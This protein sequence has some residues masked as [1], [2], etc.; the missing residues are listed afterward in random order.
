MDRAT[1]LISL[2]SNAVSKHP[3]TE[4]KHCSEAIEQYSG[5]SDNG[6]TKEHNRK[7]SL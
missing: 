5:T 7:T 4:Y 3:L 2:L 1:N 6:L